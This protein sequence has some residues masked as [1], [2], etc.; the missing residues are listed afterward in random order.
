[1]KRSARNKER[2]KELKARAKERSAALGANG[3]FWITALT[4]ALT[5]FGVVMVFSAS[6][7]NALNS[8]AQDP[9]AY[10]KKQ[11]AF[12]LIGFFLMW[13]LSRID[14]HIFQKFS[15]WIL[16]V[17]ILLL[18]AVLTPI[19]VTVNGATRW[20]PVGPV[21]IM[22]GEI[23]K[24]AMICF[25]AAFLTN[26]PDAIH[27]FSGY[28]VIGLV[29]AV[30]FIL[31]FR[32]PNLST[33]LTVVLIVLSI[34]FLDGM[35]KKVLSGMVALGVIGMVGLSMTGTYWADR[36]LSFLNPFKDPSGDGY[37]VVQSLLALGTGG[38]QGLGLGKSIQ[39]NLYLPE[40]QN[41]FIS[42]IIG[43]ELGLIG[44]LLMMLAFALLIWRGMKAAMNAP[45]RFGMLMAGGITSMIAIQ[46]I[47]NIAVVTSSMPPTGIALP[48]ISYGGNALW[49]CMGSM[50]ILLNITRQ[51]SE[52]ERLKMKQEE[53]RMEEQERS[54]YIERL[55]RSPRWSSR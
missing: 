2:R 30:V 46:V 35:S 49:I 52:K 20:I 31:I 16:L 3:D 32:Q 37:Q 18:V 28:L 8:A 11:A 40:P 55:H 53:A 9:F 6:Y 33:G 44:M 15:F 45:D 43:E 48:F 13:A 24:A 1:M 54:R 50:G 36:I 10:L 41:D 5:I 22:P 42:A 38:L 47:L 27:K 19:G 14:Y 29:T 26:F 21:T 12:A 17:S 51:S 25:T 39:K 23:A 34:M 7:Y 4:T